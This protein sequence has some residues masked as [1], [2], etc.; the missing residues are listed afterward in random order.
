MLLCC[1][2]RLQAEIKVC[3][4]ALYQKTMHSWQ[5]NANKERKD[6]IFCQLLVV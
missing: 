4:A 6:E 5:Y 3:C 1:M 2:R